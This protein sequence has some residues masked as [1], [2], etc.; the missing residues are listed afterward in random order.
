MQLHRVTSR[1]YAALNAPIGDSRLEYNEVL[2]E[3]LIEL[4]LQH[5]NLDKAK[6]MFLGGGRVFFFERESTS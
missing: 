3:N 2:V 6:G 5:G 1:L 4:E